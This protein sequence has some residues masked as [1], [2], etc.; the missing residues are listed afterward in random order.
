LLIT[1]KLFPRVRKIIVLM[2][3]NFT[4]WSKLSSNGAIICWVK[5]LSYI[6]TICN[7]PDLASL[8]NADNV[9]VGSIVYSI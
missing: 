3:K 9:C 8:G 1:Q 2:T 4:A 7:V 6:Q 5:K